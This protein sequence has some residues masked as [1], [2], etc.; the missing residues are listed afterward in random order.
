MKWVSFQK[1]E[2]KPK[3]WT[4]HTVK[5]SQHSYY[6]KKLKNNYI[7]LLKLKR[8][9]QPSKNFFSAV[10]LVTLSGHCGFFQSFS[11]FHTFCEVETEKCIIPRPWTCQQHEPFVGSEWERSTWALWSLFSCSLL[12][13]WAIV[14]S[15]FLLCLSGQSWHREYRTFAENVHACSTV[16][17]PCIVLSFQYTVMVCTNLLIGCHVFIFIFAR[18]RPFQILLGRGLIER[19]RRD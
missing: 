1:S 13:C 14:F 2:P 8:R 7:T 10:R 19:E 11:I 5:D 6:Q 17:V 12:A 16:T 9:I 18:R 3:K 15:C 4:W